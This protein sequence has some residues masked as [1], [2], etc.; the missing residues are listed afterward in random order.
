MRKI[1]VQN[2]NLSDTCFHFTLSKNLE[3]ISFQGLLPSVGENSY[4]IEKQPKIYFAKGSEGAVEILNVWIRWLIVCRVQQKKY[5]QNVTSPQEWF[6]VRQ[7]FHE[8][9]TSGKVFTDDA[10]KEAFE[11]FY[12]FTKKSSYLALDIQDKVDYDSNDID[13]VKAHNP[14]EFVKAMYGRTTNDENNPFCLERWNM[15]TKVGHKI[16]PEKI[17][18]LTYG[19]KT[20]LFSIGKYLRERTQNVDVSLLDEFYE[21]AK[22]KETTPTKER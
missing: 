20:D 8:D 6:A 4:G 1:D 5:Y 9:I 15:Q 18:Q 7:K 19:E 22:N 3:S 16:L 17:S 21:Y 11:M 10:K 13:E 12:S 14:P 2:L